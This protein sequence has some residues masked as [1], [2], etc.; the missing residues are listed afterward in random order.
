MKKF[1]AI[2]MALAIVL[3]LCACGQSNS[4]AGGRDESGQVTISVG[5][6]SSAKIISFEDNAL[7]RWLE[8]TTGY[9]LEI[10]EYSGGSDIAT[11]ISTTIA[12]R[13]DLPDV[14]WGVS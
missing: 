13:Q 11:Q 3:G 6:S 12:A 8:E 4:M 5:L 1:L 9:K 10:V 14:L 7:T 2:V